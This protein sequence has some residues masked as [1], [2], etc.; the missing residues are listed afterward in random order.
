MTVTA[1]PSGQF[2]AIYD[3]TIITQHMMALG[4]KRC[5]GGISVVISLFFSATLSIVGLGV[6]EA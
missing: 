5:R 3:S 6:A 2:D 1:L 4:E